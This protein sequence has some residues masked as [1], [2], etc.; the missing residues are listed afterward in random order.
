MSDARTVSLHPMTQ[1]EYDVRIPALVAGY[2]GD[3]LRSGRATTETALTESRRQHAELVPDGLATERMLFL[4]VRQT[5]TD[6][7][8]PVGWIWVGLPDPAEPERPAWIYNIEVDTAHRGTGYGRAILAAVEPVLA[9]RGV[10]R[11][12]LNVFGDNLAARRL[13]ESTGFTV[14]AQQMVKPIGSAPQESA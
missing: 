1:S 10:T 8:R 11:L 9:A 13:Y 5:G 3:L 4:V 7:A 12:G 14:T 6:D 2:A